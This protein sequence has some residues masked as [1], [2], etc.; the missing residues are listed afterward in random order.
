[1]RQYHYKKYKKQLAAAA[2][3]V[4]LL[5]GCGEE[6]PPETY[7]AGEDTLPA[8]GALVT[9]DEGV[10]FSSRQEDED[11]LV[12]YTYEGLS[13]GAETAQAYAKALEEDNSCIPL[14]ADG[15][16]RAGEDAFSEDSGEILLAA[17]SQTGEGLF[18]LDLS[19]DATS[20]TVTPAYAE[21]AELPAENYT[22]TLDEAV[23]YL[24]RLPPATLE[25]EGEDMSPYDIYPEDG[26]ALLDG[27]PCICMNVYYASN[28]QYCATFL[29]AGE[30]NQVYRL[31]R[32]TGQARPLFH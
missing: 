21:E 4:L 11:G 30:G 3:M 6:S 27:E 23:E 16:A 9:L 24:R 1:M 25:L 17:E 31:D 22:M 2:A 8:L 13:S 10:Q 18:E 19:W 28:H 7:A 14:T 20:C 12:S 26:V 5:S 15:K 32:S 29:V